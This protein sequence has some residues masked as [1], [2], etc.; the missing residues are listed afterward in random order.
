M[1]VFILTNRYLDRD[2]FDPPSVRSIFRGFEQTVARDTPPTTSQEMLEL[3][4]GPLIFQGF[5]WQD[6]GLFDARSWTSGCY[7]QDMGGMTWPPMGTGEAR[8]ELPI[9]RFVGILN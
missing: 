5:G 9:Y 4:I 2:E 7:R 8:W 3:G 6:L 1:P